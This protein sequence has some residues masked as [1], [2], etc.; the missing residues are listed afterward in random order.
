MTTQPEKTFRAKYEIEDGYA[1]GS[2]PQN[3][4]ISAADLE[5][6]MTPSDLEDLYMELCEE[7]MHDNIGCSP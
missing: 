5:D 4:K 3:F 1:G 7:H 2:R 6:D